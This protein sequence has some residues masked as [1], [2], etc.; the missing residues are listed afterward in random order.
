MS[1]SENLQNRTRQNTVR[2]AYWT[3]SWVATLAI[4]VYGPMLVWDAKAITLLMIAV[5]LLVGVGMIF[6]NKA[7]LKGLDEL[8]Q[9]IHLEAMAI[10]LGVGL[11]AGISYSTLETTQL[12]ASKAEISHLVILMGLTYLVSIIIGQAKY[13]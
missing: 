8:Q 2:L 12:I 1:Q 7:H 3:F 5:N 10:T 11:I 6:A 4:A 13:R 9:K